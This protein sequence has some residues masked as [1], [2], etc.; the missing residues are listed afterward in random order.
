MLRGARKC[1][2]CEL[3]I[4]FCEWCKTRSTLSYSFLMNIVAF[5]SFFSKYDKIRVCTYF[6][7]FCEHLLF[8][9]MSCSIA[10]FKSCFSTFVSAAVFCWWETIMPIA[11][12]DV[13]ENYS[14]PPWS[15]YQNNTAWATVFKPLWA[16]RWAT[17]LLT[18]TVSQVWAT[19]PKNTEPVCMFV[20]STIVVMVFLS[21]LAS[22][23]CLLF[24]LLCLFTNRSVWWFYSFPLAHGVPLF[25][26]TCTCVLLPV[27]VFLSLLLLV[28]QIVTLLFVCA[29]LSVYWVWTTFESEI[30]ILLKVFD[31][32]FW[33]FYKG[34]KHPD[35][36]SYFEIVLFKKNTFSLQFFFLLLFFLSII[37][38]L[39]EITKGIKLKDKG[40]ND[41]SM[42]NSI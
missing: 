2:L 41:S 28:L 4:N 8:A 6:V 39:S 26:S 40:Q 14:Q 27:F 11:P 37:E 12:F 10:D 32:T 1:S 24:S 16:M 31:G 3:T 38:M 30:Q 42:M 21:C 23:L 36:S 22:C 33:K 9:W 34:P 19:I 17:L 29:N 18:I 20:L 5:T 15:R 7:T 25:L 35:I 13:V